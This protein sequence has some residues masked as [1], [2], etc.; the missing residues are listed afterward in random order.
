MSSFIECYTKLTSNTALAI[1]IRGYI[2][3]GVEE[4]LK[5]S[6]CEGKVKRQRP[7]NES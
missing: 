1:L 7:Y 3:N 4:Q 6:K 5:Y 2:Q